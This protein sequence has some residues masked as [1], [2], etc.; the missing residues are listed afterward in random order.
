ME[1]GKYQIAWYR[2]RGLGLV[3]L[4]SLVFFVGAYVTNQSAI[5]ASTAVSGWKGPVCRVK[6][7]EKKA[8]LTFDASFSAGQI[9]PILKILEKYGVK[10]T[11]FVTGSWVENYPEYVKKIAQQ[12]HELGNGSQNHQDMGQLSVSEI[13]TEL[14]FVYDRVRELT[15]TE[16][17]VFRAPYG[18]YEGAV[19]E[20]VNQ[21]GY[22]PIQW[23]VDTEDWKDYGVES[24]I[25]KAT[26][27]PELSNG[28]ILRMHS[29]AKYTAQALE[30]VIVQLQEQGYELVPV[31]QLVYWSGY[32]IDAKGTQIPD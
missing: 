28:S 32:H 1:K 22:L 24:I 8:A 19:L 6:M 26:E 11:F 12:G 29:D 2:L 17:K 15:G 23:N 18:D 27:S 9:E 21:S 30:T 10:A 5:T 14:G 20:T 31:S 25:Q 4:C 16:I 13:Q 7:E 3:C